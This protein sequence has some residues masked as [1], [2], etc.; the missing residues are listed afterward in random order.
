MIDVSYVCGWTPSN[1]DAQLFDLCNKHINGELTS[2]PNLKRWFDNMKSYTPMERL[3]FAAPKGE[4]SSLSIKVDRLINPV[5]CS[6]K[7]HDKKVRQ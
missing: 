7:N 1:K 3:A 2:W 6:D 4:N 5:T